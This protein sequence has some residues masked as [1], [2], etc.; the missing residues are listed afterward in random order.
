MQISELMESNKR[1]VERVHV[2]EE[3]QKAYRNDSGSVHEEVCVWKE[4]EC[5]NR[6]ICVHYN[7]NYVSE[8]Q[9][10]SDYRND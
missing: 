2:L 3:I 1:L 4:I 8:M 6:S 7:K 10:L 9:R 5:R